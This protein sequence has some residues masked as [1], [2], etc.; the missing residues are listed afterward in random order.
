[1]EIVLNEFA[2]LQIGGLLYLKVLKMLFGGLA[3]LIDGSLL[4]S[5]PLAGVE[6]TTV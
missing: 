5:E 3:L 6:V 1:V 4:F 2:C